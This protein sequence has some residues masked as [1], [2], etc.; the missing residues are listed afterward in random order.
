MMKMVFKRSALALAAMLTA[1]NPAFAQE[2]AVTL[3]GDVLL[4]RTVVDDSGAQ[5]TER[6]APETI[7]PGD[8]LVFTTTYVNK[9]AEAVTDFVVTSPLPDAVR[10]APDAADNLVVSVDSGS[11][12]GALDTLTLADP[13]GAVRPATH[14]DVT[15]I[16]WT[17]ASLAAGAEGTLEYP[18][19]IR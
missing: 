4:E 6:V 12:F 10:L 13:D 11:T 14:D 17:L 15:H 7:V 18:A 19:I 16:R 1:T 9:G 3:T 5:T 2:R 8:R